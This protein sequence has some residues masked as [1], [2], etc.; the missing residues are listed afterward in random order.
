M[1][2]NDPA[3]ALDGASVFF[4]RKLVAKLTHI[5][6]GKLLTFHSIHPPK[7]VL[8]PKGVCK[9]RTGIGYSSILL[10]HYV[11]IHK[12]PV[13][14]VPFYIGKGI[15]DRAYAT[16]GRS[17][18]WDAARNEILHRHGMD[19]EVEI[20]AAFDE[21]EKAFELEAV[22]IYRSCLLGH[23]LVNKIRP[24]DKS[25][26]PPEEGPDESQITPLSGIVKFRRKNLKL[27]QA[28]FA[29]YAGVGLR[30]IRELEQAKK[31]TLRMDKVNHVL[32]MFGLTLSAT[33]MKPE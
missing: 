3:N 32:G 15:G 13:S 17:T 26:F 18:E 5:L 25:D 30:F 14:K 6:H 1:L 12:D 9:T 21:E 27:S 31:I 16:Q 29:D 8:Y 19:R 24:K 22:E 2:Q 20:L 7:E 33:K 10:K 23:L 4:L 11:Y 28:Q